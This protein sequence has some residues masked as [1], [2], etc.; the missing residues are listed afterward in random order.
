MAILQERV[1]MKDVNGPEMYITSPT[2]IKTERTMK[3]MQIIQHTMN[4]CVLG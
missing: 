3:T 2:G 1:T 4:G